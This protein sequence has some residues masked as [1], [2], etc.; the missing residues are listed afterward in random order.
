M[1]NDGRY[2]RAPIDDD[3]QEELT[4]IVDDS[5]DSVMDEL[6]DGSLDC[7]DEL[8]VAAHETV[9]TEIPTL[10]SDDVNSRL[11]KLEK[12]IENI[13]KQ[14]RFETPMVEQ[15][16]ENNRL[17][18]DSSSFPG[19]I[20]K[21][22][23][24]RWDLIPKFP[25]DIP[26]N[27]L[28]ENWQSFIENF[29]IAA[30]L[31][32]FGCPSDRAKLLYLTIGKNLQDIINAANL[33]P[34]YHD[35]RCYSTLVEGINNY[36]KSMTDTAAEHDAFQAMRQAKGES[37]V[38]FHARLTQKVRLCGYSPT[39]QTRFILAQL[40]KG[41]QNRELAVAARTYGHN[42]NYIVQAGTRVEAYKADE[43]VTEHSSDVYAVDRE[44]APSRTNHESQPS[45][46]FKKIE[47]RRATNPKRPKGFS[48]NYREGRRSR[49]W[50]CGF[51][52]HKSD[53][54]PALDKRCN[55]CGREGHY[56]IMCRKNHVNNIREEESRPMVSR[57]WKKDPNNDQV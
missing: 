49:C 5:D 48:Q 37:I 44:K 46:S 10:H 9:E 16:D 19:Y 25:K 42:A 41:M 47:E 36:F 26:S 8:E 4:P 3:N 15:C 27:K 34:N 51:M 22:S 7:A 29:E 24:I 2:V 53:K 23:N 43:V 35:P 55:S 13:A 54:C 38:A 20:D 50:R 17:G 30:S 32:T 45:R 28:W 14:R 21:G 31:S 6:N 12:M 11:R 39:D 18:P 57:E 33:Q 56:A 1:S 40:L 52:F